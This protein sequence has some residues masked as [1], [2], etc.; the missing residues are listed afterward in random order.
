MKIP[1][2]ADWLKTEFS[3]VQLA[4]TTP[5]ITQIVN[6]AVRYWNTHSGFKYVRM[7]D[8]SNVTVDK[9]Q[10]GT[11][12]GVTTSFILATKYANIVVS[13][14]TIYA[15]IADSCFQITDDGLGNLSD[16]G[17]NVTGTIVYGTGAITLV[18]LTAPNTDAPIIISYNI[19]AQGGT[20]M[21][22]NP[23]FKLVTNIYPAVTPQLLWQDNTLW[24]LFGITILDN[25]TSDLIMMTQAFQNYQL[26][27]G[28]DFRWTWEPAEDPA[29]MGT[30]YYTNNP[31][32]NSLF[33]IVGAK[34]ILPNEDIKSEHILDWLL[35]YSKALLKMC[36][37]NMLR[38]GDIIGVKNDG[39]A[40]LDEGKEEMEALQERLAQE[41]RW[42]AMAQRF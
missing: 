17:G 3:D 5:T 37:G 19:T 20:A 36:E 4:T 33:C 24:K 29:E 11:G 2:I 6:N 41:G 21:P 9:E 34:R 27:V 40:M 7:Y 15:S 12:N 35:Y 32:M 8:M 14:V 42:L 26:Y 18:F 28:T 31:I 25:V 1:E 16:V 22:I 10:I 13:T 39:Q 30:V 38:K 23:D